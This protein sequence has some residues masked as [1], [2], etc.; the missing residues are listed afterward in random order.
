MLSFVIFLVS[1]TWDF[2][3]FF[4]NF[5]LKKAHVGLSRIVGFV[6]VPKIKPGR[7]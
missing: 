5:K 4:E 2:K 6:F 7:F 3:Y 1:S